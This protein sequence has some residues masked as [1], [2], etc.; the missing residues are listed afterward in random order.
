MVSFW[1]EHP[2]QHRHTTH[3]VFTHKLTHFWIILH[4][5]AISSTSH[6]RQQYVPKTVIFA[7]V[8]KERG[9][10]KEPE[11]ATWENRYHQDFAY[12]R[13]FLSFSLVLSPSLSHALTHPLS[14]P[15]PS[16]QYYCIISNS[17]ECTRSR[18]IA[19]EKGRYFRELECLKYT[20]RVSSSE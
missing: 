14:H 5:D 15:P 4:A 6:K 2:V 19:R 11:A 20:Q 10:W 3:I 18:E 13:S 7:T 16:S 12:S 17:N 9:K 1:R 8:Y